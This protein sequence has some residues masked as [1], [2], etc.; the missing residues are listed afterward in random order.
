VKIF[1][2]LGATLLAV[3]VF[4]NIAYSDPIIV[5]NKADFLALV[6]DVVTEGFEGFPTEF[7]STGGSSPSS[8]ISTPLMTVSTSPQGGGTSF[9]CIGTT[10]AGLPGPTEGS[11]ALIAGSNTGDPWILTF[12]LTDAVHAVWFELT[13]AVER[14]DAFISIDGLD[15]ILIASQGSGGVNTVFF[16]IITDNPFTEFSLINTGISDGWGV[17]QIMLGQITEPDSDNDGILDALDRC[18]DT[19]IPEA[20][21]TRRLGVNRFALEDGD[22]TFDTTPPKGIGPQAS[23]TLVDTAGCSCEQIVDALGLGQGHTKFGCSISAMEDFIAQVQ[24]GPQCVALLATGQTNCW[25]SSGAMIDCASTG[26]DGEL[27]AGAAR[28]YTDNGDGTITDN[29]TGLMWEKLTDDGTIHDVDTSS[30]WDQ[31]FQKIA[32]LNAANFAGHSD[33]RL[34]NVNEL[35]SLADYGRNS[36]A[37][38]PVFNDGVDSF[39][40]FTPSPNINSLAPFYWSSTTSDFLPLFA[41]GVSFN[42]GTVIFN[43]SLDKPDGNFVRAVRGP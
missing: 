13:D 3:F 39:T 10:A 31:A 1:T 28:S 2:S 43:I 34:P 36:P 19:V 11:N 42:F 20:V 29:T 23:F 41:W 7:C 24:P 6:S 21:P 26:Q 35:Q 5:R 18:P 40:R 17:D 27:Q 12:S 32:D 8:S 15:D 25:D 4:S 37:I 30:T 33:W 22:T 9:L 16:G 14:G 38:D